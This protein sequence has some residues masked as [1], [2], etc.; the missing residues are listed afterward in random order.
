MLRR[1]LVGA[2]AGACL[3]IGASGV[4][5]AAPSAQD[6]T[7]MVAAHQ[8]NLAEIAAGNAAISRAT[9]DEVRSLGE[10]FVAM[11]TELDSNLTAAAG[12]LGVA[13][14]AT[15]TPAQQ[16]ALAQV[17]AQQGAAFDTAWI[18]N[19]VAGHRTSL[20]ATRLEIDAGSDPAVVALANT[21]APVVEQHLASVEALSTAAP[22]LVQ[23]GDGGL[24]DDPSNS[25]IV[26]CVLAA[27]GLVAVAAMLR[28]HRSRPT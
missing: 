14:P 17:E 26:A 25:W 19:Q 11:H 20:E 16:Q 9:T 21:A 1:S 15:P 4:A 23:T 5:T 27:A 6:S 8:S 10:M 28:T 2:I 7:W 24:L 18:S 3:M 13:L 22:T 12:Q